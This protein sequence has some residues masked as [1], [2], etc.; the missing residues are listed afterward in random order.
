MARRHR[1]GTAC[2]SHGHVFSYTPSRSHDYTNRPRPNADARADLSREFESLRFVPAEDVPEW[3][4]NIHE[5]QYDPDEGGR[6]GGGAPAGEDDSYTLKVPASQQ[7]KQRKR[8]WYYRF[9]D[10]WL[11]GGILL[12]AALLAGWVFMVKSFRRCIIRNIEK[13]RL[14]KNQ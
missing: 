4:R 5:D 11:I 14:A 9:L 10:P 8:R 1:E 13:M 6:V 7:S 2:T 3:R 12:I